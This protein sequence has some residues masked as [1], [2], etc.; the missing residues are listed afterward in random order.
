MVKNQFSQPAAPGISCCSNP[1]FCINKIQPIDAI[2]GGVIKGIINTISKNLYLANF[3]LEKRY[4][5]GNA[6]I[7]DTRTTSI[8]RS[9]E[10]PIIFKLLLFFSVCTAIDISRCPSVTTAF[11]NI[12]TSGHT[13]RNINITISAGTLMF[14]SLL[15]I[16]MYCLIL[17]NSIWNN[18]LH[19]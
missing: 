7:V 11:A 9:S 15:F 5:R 4:A 19:I 12:I 2:Y 14:F 10:L 13:I 1:L 16:S 17:P 6:I 3:V 8:E 18:I